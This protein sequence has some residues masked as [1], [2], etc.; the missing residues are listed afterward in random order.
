[1][2]LIEQVRNSDFFNL[3]QSINTLEADKRKMETCI[4]QLKSEK[5]Q[6][7]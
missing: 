6:Y 5:E 4:S 2:E 3:K 7:S 1:M